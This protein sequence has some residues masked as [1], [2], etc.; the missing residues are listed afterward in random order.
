[1]SVTEISLLDACATLRVYETPNAGC[2]GWMRGVRELR[3]ENLRAEELRAENCAE[4]CVR[5]LRRVDLG[6]D[7]ARV[8]RLVVREQP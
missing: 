8:H 6:V 2:G 1:M 5:H 3:A 4:N 7:D